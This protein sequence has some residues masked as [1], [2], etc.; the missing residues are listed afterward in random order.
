[1]VSCLKSGAG[2]QAH[3]RA[4][5]PSPLCQLGE[6]SQLGVTFIEGLWEGSEV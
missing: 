5:H 2:I 3:L 1:M 6:E 4:D